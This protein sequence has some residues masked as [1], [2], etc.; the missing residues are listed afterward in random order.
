MEGS[1]ND[2][3][4]YSGKLKLLTSP[5]R[6]DAIDYLRDEDEV[7]LEDLTNYLE[8][9][10]YNDISSEVIHVHLP[11]LKDYGVIEQDKNQINYQGDEVVEEVIETLEDLENE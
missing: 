7:T 9:I 10:G 11:I 8:S 1:R 3:E 4:E 2:M 6:I 5:E